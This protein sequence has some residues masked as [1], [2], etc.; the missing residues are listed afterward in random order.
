MN[1]R[2]HRRTTKVNYWWISGHNNYWADS[3][4]RRRREISV[5]GKAA[6][7]GRHCGQHN[8]DMLYA[9]HTSCWCSYSRN[10]IIVSIFYWTSARFAVRTWSV[11]RIRDV[12]PI[13]RRVAWF[14]DSRQT[15]KSHFRLVN[16]SQSAIYRTNP[17]KLAPCTQSGVVVTHWCSKKWGQIVNATASC[18]WNICPICLFNRIVLRLTTQHRNLSHS[19]Y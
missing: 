8:A 13:T 4:Q 2:F 12:T 7:R 19:V 14:T 15:T 5:I 18:R 9:C 17:A 16:R 1:S 6:A 3:G 11:T 10:W